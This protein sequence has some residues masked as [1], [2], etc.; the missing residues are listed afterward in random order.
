MHTLAE[1]YSGALLSMR[2][3]LTFAGLF[4]GLN[5]EVDQLCL[6]SN[7]ISIWSIYLFASHVKGNRSIDDPF[8]F[9]NLFVYNLFN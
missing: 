9:Y 3:K 4:S 1:N 8:P 2:S 5:D 7:V 6:W